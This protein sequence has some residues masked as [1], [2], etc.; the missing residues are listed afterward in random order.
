M[1]TLWILAKEDGMKDF[2]RTKRL[3]SAIVLA[4]F[5][6]GALLGNAIA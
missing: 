1:V 2:S 4:S 6:A 3:G 5:L